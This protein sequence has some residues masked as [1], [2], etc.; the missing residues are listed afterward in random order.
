M[1]PPKF[2]SKRRLVLLGSVAAIGAA[3][4]LA[5]P[6]DGTQARSEHRVHSATRSVQRRHRVVVGAPSNNP[7]NRTT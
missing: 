2:L 4:I 1:V 7:H 5:A 3:V 6:S